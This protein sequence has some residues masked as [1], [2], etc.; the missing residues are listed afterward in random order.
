[1]K[2]IHSDQILDVSALVGIVAAMALMLP[3]FVMP[4]MGA[5]AVPASVLLM[6]SLL[7]GTR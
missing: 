5:L 7:C 3:A 1:M 2:S 6:A 4:G